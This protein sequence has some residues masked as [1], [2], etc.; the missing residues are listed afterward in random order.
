MII[1]AK[2]YKLQIR[3]GNP[4][5]HQR[6]TV[7]SLMTKSVYNTGN[8]WKPITLI[9]KCNKMPFLAS[10][11][12]HSSSSFQRASW[13]WWF[14]TPC[15]QL[16]V[17]PSTMAVPGRVLALNHAVT[18]SCDRKAGIMLL[19]VEP[20]R[21]VGASR[22]ASAHQHGWQM[23]TKR[24]HFRRCQ[25]GQTGFSPWDSSAWRHQMNDTWMVISIYFEAGFCICLSVKY[26]LI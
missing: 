16:S 20:H 21:S 2:P 8:I 4:G 10:L 18:H 25:A 5:V 7:L 23:S 12:T 24:F 15:L 17:P 19:Y 6:K 3:H 26:E 14:V 11:P 1:C 13:V 22:D 9:W